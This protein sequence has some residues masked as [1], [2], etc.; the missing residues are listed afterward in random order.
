MRGDSGRVSRT[1]R[2]S[3][4]WAD[5]AGGDTRS[6]VC[7]QTTM[8]LMREIKANLIFVGYI[9]GQTSAEWRK[10]RGIPKATP[11]FDTSTSYTVQ[12]VGFLSYR[13]VMYF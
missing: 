5:W 13:Q 11:R 4:G 6:T 3:E 12:L 2:L 9:H 7:H 8:D 10:H 1:H